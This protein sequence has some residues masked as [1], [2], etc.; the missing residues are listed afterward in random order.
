MSHFLLLYKVQRDGE[1]QDLKRGWRHSQSFLEKLEKL[2]REPQIKRGSSSHGLQNLF[3]ITIAFPGSESCCL[4]AYSQHR[5]PPPLLHLKITLQAFLLPKRAWEKKSGGPVASRRDAA[6]PVGLVVH[7]YRWDYL[8]TTKI[9]SRE[10][11]EVGIF[12]SLRHFVSLTLAAREAPA[13]TSSERATRVHVGGW[14]LQV[15][16]L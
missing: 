8:C 4:L 2:L 12:S 6:P 5:K 11:T 3:S 7:E 15:A 9:Q 14:R 1:E 16:L 10:V 13:A